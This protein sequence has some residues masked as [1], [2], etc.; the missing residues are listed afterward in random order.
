M[1]K[2]LSKLRYACDEYKMIQDNDNIAVGLSGGKDSLIL[3]ALLSKL[4]RF[5]PAKFGLKAI[6]IDPYFNCK[7][8]DT[9]K[10]YEFCNKLGVEFLHEKSNIYD[11]VFN[12]RKEKNPC[13]L[14]ANM[15]RGILCTVAVNNNC[16]KMA[17]G[18]HLD[19]AVETF[20][21]NLLNGGTI[22]CFSP[23]T[24][25]SRKDITLIR[26]LIYCTENV[27]SDFSERLNFPI[28]KSRCPMDKI[29]NREKTSE[30]I[31]KLQL[32][33]PDIKSKV[34]GAMKRANISEW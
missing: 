24:Y 18:H 17:L 28:L 26:P 34:I 5:Y 29:S 31:Q 32:K 9:S 10:L 21:M 2:L 27:I 1:D 30:L 3:L 23:V 15:R 20:F 33:Y 19:D 6:F 13:S 8:T 16:N 4:R 11:V 12:V 25:L 7:K 22:S 14:C